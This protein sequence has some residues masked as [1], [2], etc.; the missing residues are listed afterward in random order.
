MRSRKP[1]MAKTAD[2]IGRL[3]IGR[4]F[5][6]FPLTVPANVLAC[7]STLAHASTFFGGPHERRKTS[8]TGTPGAAD[9]GRGLPAWPRYC[10]GSPCRAFRPAQLFVS[11]CHA[12]TAG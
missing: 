1:K 11:A 5:L 4:N 10:H 7:A 3:N 2:P 6:F 8:S 9:Y 12:R